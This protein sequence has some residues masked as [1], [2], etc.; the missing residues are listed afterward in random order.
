MEKKITS[1]AEGF[2]QIFALSA[3][4]ADYWQGDVAQEYREIMKELQKEAE[5]L[6]KKNESN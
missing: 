3:K 4:T 5:A 2:S 1:V 6:V